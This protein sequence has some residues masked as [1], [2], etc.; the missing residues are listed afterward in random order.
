MVWNSRGLASSGW[1][2]ATELGS[3]YATLGRFFW[4]ARGVKRHVKNKTH[5]EWT[6]KMTQDA[7]VFHYP[8]RDHAGLPGGDGGQLFQIKC[9]R[10]YKPLSHWESGITH[11]CKEPESVHTQQFPWKHE[12]MSGPWQTDQASS[13]LITADCCHT[14]I[15]YLCSIKGG[16]KPFNAGW[17]LFKY[18]DVVRKEESAT[19]LLASTKETRTSADVTTKLATAAETSR[20]RHH[21][22]HHPPLLHR[23]W[24]P[25]RHF[26]RQQLP[27]SGIASINN[28]CKQTSWP[29]RAAIDE[30]LSR[31]VLQAA[32][33]MSLFGLI[34]RFSPRLKGLFDAAY[35]LAETHL[36]AA[37]G[38]QTEGVPAAICCG[39]Y[40]DGVKC[41]KRARFKKLNW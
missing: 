35:R 17:I 18:L 10:L 6:H 19:S 14:L 9:V 7:G 41:L 37:P 20:Q 26:H 13:P 24:G 33:Q 36:A 16:R 12:W 39:E 25:V 11:T 38:P 3:V 32:C 4:H 34:I 22:S 29:I 21:L 2:Q 1:M 5:T 23:C 28:Y 8:I 40:S 31:S 15:V 27:Q 30:P